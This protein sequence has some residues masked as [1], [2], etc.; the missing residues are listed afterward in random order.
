MSIE[1]QNVTQFNKDVTEN[2]GYKYTTNEQYSSVVANKRI[3]KATLASIPENI[4]SLIDI[5]CGDGTY[6]NVLKENLPEVSCTGFD[7]A[8]I[9]I[10]NAKNKFRNIEFIVGDVM[11][12]DTFPTQ[13]Y[14]FGVIRGV[15]HH[16]PDA[17][18]GIT[19]AT[20]LSDR[21]LIIEPNG[22]N[23]ILK[24]IE[25]KSKYHIDHEEQSY[26]SKQLINWCEQTGYK[27]TKVEYIG[28]VPFFFPTFFAKIIYFFQPFLELIYPVKKYFSAQIVILYEKKLS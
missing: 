28:F 3:I 20:K 26:S 12:T 10:E 23:P 1:K 17:A 14:D 24:W 9:A 16:L 7:P 11:N 22:N 27:V 18:T 8:D 19:N 25:K 15:I 5:G 4:S 6:T 13:K 2:N 21:I